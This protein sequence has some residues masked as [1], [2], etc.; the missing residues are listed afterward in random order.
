MISPVLSATLTPVLTAV[1]TAVVISEVAFAIQEKYHTEAIYQCRPNEGQQ[2]EVSLH[3]RIQGI[4]P[5]KF[6]GITVFQDDDGNWMRN[7][8]PMNLTEYME[9]RVVF[10]TGSDLRLR[11]DRVQVEDYKMKTFA[12]IP[13]LKIYTN[14]WTCKGPSYEDLPDLK[15]KK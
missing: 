11:F 7:V 15:P 5:Q 13:S 2:I 6:V 4:G 9:G 14:E 12:Q 3:R 1:F 10:F 8:T